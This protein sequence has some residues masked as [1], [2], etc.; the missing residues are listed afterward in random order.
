MDALVALGT[1]GFALH[2]AFYLVNFFFGLFI[3]LFIGY[4]VHKSAVLR[5]V[6]ILLL[7][8]SI[9]DNKTH[10]SETF[11]G[12]K[13]WSLIWFNRHIKYIMRCSTKR[14]L[15]PAKQIVISGAAAIPQLGK[16]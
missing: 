4:C 5:Q 2:W 12:V 1:L 16:K 3:I 8:F 14:K 7:C 6:I 9:Y 10:A 15:N 11:E 13:I